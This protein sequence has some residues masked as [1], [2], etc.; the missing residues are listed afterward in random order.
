VI[1]QKEGVVSSELGRNKTA[2]I[3]TLESVVTWSRPARIPVDD[4]YSKGDEMLLYFCLTL[5]LY[6][7]LC[8][9]PDKMYF[10]HWTKMS[11]VTPPPH[12]R[13]LSLMASRRSTRTHTVA[14]LRA[15]PRWRR[16]RTWEVGGLSTLPPTQ[17]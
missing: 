8:N 6:A 7:V 16:G 3:I 13:T 9:I 14:D 1:W 2:I 10:S 5:D 17:V 11:I 15:P 4:Q 12:R